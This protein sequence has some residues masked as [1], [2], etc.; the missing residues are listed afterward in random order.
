VYAFAK[1][2]GVKQLEKILGQQLPVVLDALA[3]ELC[4][5]SESQVA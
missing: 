3:D 1:D 2:G 5:N 4:Q